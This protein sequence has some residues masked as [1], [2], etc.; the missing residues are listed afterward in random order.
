MKTC[1]VGAMLIGGVLGASST[2]SAGLTWQGLVNGGDFDGSSSIR[3]LQ[4][5][6][7]SITTGWAEDAYLNAAFGAATYSNVNAPGASVSFSGLTPSGE[8]ANSWSTSAIVPGAGDGYDPYAAFDAAP[9]FFSVTGTQ[10]VTLTTAA[11]LVGGSSWQIWT[12]LNGGNEPIWSFDSTVGTATAA[13]TQT[14][15]LL[16]GQYYMNASMLA[17]AGFSGDMFSFTV[18]A[19]GAAALIG[20]AGFVG[21]RRRKA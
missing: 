6:N 10:K 18:P 7:F 1:A 17:G 2:A 5:G 19:P 8:N 13:N 4:V 20:L 14:F 11:G 3:A 12:L 21:G 16:E 9:F 15:T